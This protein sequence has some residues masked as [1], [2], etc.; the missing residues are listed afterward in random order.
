MNLDV[1]QSGKSSLES[2]RA[3]EYEFTLFKTIKRY[4]PRCLF[5]QVDLS[6]YK[7]IRFITHTHIQKLIH[8]HTIHCAFLLP[9]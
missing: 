2:Y 7:V 6:I 3:K 4:W 9:R 1:V 5:S 8:K